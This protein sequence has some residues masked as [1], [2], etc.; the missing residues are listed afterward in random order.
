LA[1]WLFSNSLELRDCQPK[2]ALESF[3]RSIRNVFDCQDPAL[4]ASRFAFLETRFDIMAE[5]GGYWRSF[6]FDVSLLERI[7]HEDPKTLAESITHAEREFFLGLT[8][9]DFEETE[10][11]ILCCNLDATRSSTLAND[12][13]ACFS[14]NSLLLRHVVHLVKVG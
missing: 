3:F 10:A 4:L 8:P 7:T 6:S 11:K 12:I 14:V 5:D 9:E 13:I 1:C 2:S